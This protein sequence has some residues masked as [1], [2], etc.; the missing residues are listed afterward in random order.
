[1]RYSNI[2]NNKKNIQQSMQKYT[3]RSVTLELSIWCVVL[4]WLVLM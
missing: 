2:V 4:L 1:M 3:A